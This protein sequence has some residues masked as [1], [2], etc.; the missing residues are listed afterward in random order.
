M[1]DVSGLTREELEDMITAAQ[2]RLQ[3]MEDQQRQAEQALGD[4]ASILADITTLNEQAAAV[5][6]VIDTPN[7]T[8]KA[9]PQLAIKTLARA[10]IRSIN[11]DVRTLRLVGQVYDGLEGDDPGTATA[12]SK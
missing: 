2:L 7:A 8:I 12:G 4:P 6:E 5:R 9:D 11:A 3:E 10:L 1:T